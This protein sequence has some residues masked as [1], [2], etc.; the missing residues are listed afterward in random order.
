MV[1]E[2]TVPLPPPPDPTQVPLMEK[3]PAAMLMP[4]S[5]ENV[6]VAVEK[7]MPFVLPM[8]KSEP[9]VVVLMPTLPL[10]SIVIVEVAESVT[11]FAA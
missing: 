10:E 8:E 7:L 9:G 6:E 11:P 4:P 3:Q 5:A 2:P 1:P